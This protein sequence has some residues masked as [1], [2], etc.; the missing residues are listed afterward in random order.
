MTFSN[1][2]GVPNPTSASGGD[3][4]GSGDSVRL[5]WPGG[6]GAGAESAASEVAEAPEAAPPVQRT[7]AAADPDD[8]PFWDWS[9]D[10]SELDDPSDALAPDRPEYPD[11]PEV[12]DYAGHRAPASADPPQVV[13][14]SQEPSRRPRRSERRSERNQDQGNQVLR[15]PGQVVVTPVSVQED[16]PRREGIGQHLGSLAHLSADPR[17]RVW[18]WRTVIAVVI[19]VGLWIPGYP[20]VGLTLAVLV[21][22]ADTIIRSRRVFVGPAAV[23]QAAARRSTRRQLAKLERAG[24]RAVH[25]IAIPGTEDQIDHLVIGPAGVFAIDSEAW[26][27]RLPVR[28]RNGRQLW[29]GPFSMQDRLDHARWEA[30]RAATRLSGVL[31]TPV[32]VRPAMAVYGPKIHWDVANIRDVDVFSGPRLRTYLRRVARQKDVRLLSD[33]EVEKIDK[34][35]HTAFPQA[36]AG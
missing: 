33:G 24:Y 18:L 30:E 20:L 6:N 3:E 27:K 16:Q 32:T 10:Q 31:G 9:A 13:P 7:E 1:R 25:D 19:L 5:L 23:R 2:G 21:V 36:T 22:I 29:H 28:T 4:S 35:T 15:R 11:G 17:R 26:D 8:L 34:A 12:P 14:A